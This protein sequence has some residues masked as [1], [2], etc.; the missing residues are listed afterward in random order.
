MTIYIPWMFICLIIVFYFFY[1]F[2][3]KNE[4]KKEQRRE[5]LME[6]QDDLILTLRNKHTKDDKANT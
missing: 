4:L 1:S 6:M 5:R 2:K 3:R